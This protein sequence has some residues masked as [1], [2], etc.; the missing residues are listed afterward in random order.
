MSKELILQTMEVA[1]NEYDKK[2]MTVD[3]LFWKDIQKRIKKE[4]QD[5]W[6]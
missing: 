3:A 5:R 1:I 2:G 6:V 4:L